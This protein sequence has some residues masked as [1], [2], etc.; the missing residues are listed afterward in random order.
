MAK[1][2][3]LFSNYEIVHQK[4]RILNFLENLKLCE[5]CIGHKRCVSDISAGFVPKISRSEKYL[6][7]YA[8]NARTEA[9][10]L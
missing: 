2:A 5:N 4:T 1:S 6:G 7:S 10:R 3:E 9:R 8:R